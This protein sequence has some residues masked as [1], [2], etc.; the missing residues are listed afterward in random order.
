MLMKVFGRLILCHYVL[1]D[2]DDLVL[3]QQTVSI[4]SKIQVQTNVTNLK[5]IFFR[6]S[7]VNVKSS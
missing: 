6:A 2:V 7:R 3:T 4:N 5:R 1:V